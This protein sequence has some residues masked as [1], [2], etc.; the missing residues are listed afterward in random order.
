M[1]R[2]FI[3]LSNTFNDNK[4]DKYNNMIEKTLEKDHQMELSNSV[5][6]V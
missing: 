4:I 2:Q 6:S 3:L 5:V 1:W